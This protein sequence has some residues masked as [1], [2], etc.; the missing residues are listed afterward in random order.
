MP[1]ARTLTT[2]ALQAATSIAGEVQARTSAATRVGAASASVIA[3]MPPSETPQTMAVST[4][5][6]SM[7]AMASAASMARL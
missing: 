2:R 1:S 6:A 4:P 7:T 3:T 5:A